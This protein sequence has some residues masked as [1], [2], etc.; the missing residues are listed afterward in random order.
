MNKQRKNKFFLR[1]KKAL[2]EVIDSIDNTSILNEFL[3]ADK[4]PGN[5]EIK[6]SF[7]EIEGKDFLGVNN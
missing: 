1:L 5:I 3:E 4:D 6:Q 7:S 2:E